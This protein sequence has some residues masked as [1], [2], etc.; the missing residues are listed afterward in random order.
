MYQY[1]RLKGRIIKNPKGVIWGLIIEKVVEANIE[2]QLLDEQGSFRR[3]MGCVNQVF[4][5]QIIAENIWE[6]EGILM[7]LDK[8]YDR[9]NWNTMW[10][11]LEHHGVYF[12]LL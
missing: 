5:V 7:D 12:L 2:R 1:L 4:S 8:V 6:R 9:V 11:V 10:L 3:N